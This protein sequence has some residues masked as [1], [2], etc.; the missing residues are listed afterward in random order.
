MYKTRQAEAYSSPIK[1]VLGG[2][3]MHLL[4]KDEDNDITA[5]VTLSQEEAL[6]LVASLSKA[7]MRNWK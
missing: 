4:C 2:E 5:C 7:I 3:Q 6:N 1:I